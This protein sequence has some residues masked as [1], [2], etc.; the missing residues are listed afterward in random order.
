MAR[1]LDRHPTRPARR[2]RLRLHDPPTTPTPSTS[3]LSNSIKPGS[4]HRASSGSTAPKTRATPGSPSATACLSATSC[5]AP[6]DKPSATTPR[7]N[8]PPS[9][10]ISAP[11]AATSTPPPTA[12]SWQQILDHLAPIPPSV[13]PNSPRRSPVLFSAGARS[14]ARPRSRGGAPGPGVR[15]EG[16]VGGKERTQPSN[17]RKHGRP[18]FNADLPFQGIAGGMGEPP[19]PLPSPPWTRPSPSAAPPT[20]A[21]SP[22]PPSA[23]DLSSTP[24]WATSNFASS[25]AKSA[26]GPRSLPFT[27]ASYAVAARACPIATAPTSPRPSRQTTSS[28]SRMPWARTNSI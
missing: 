25:S 22:T 18:E 6:I 28:P 20:A 24:T 17:P 19:N 27:V 14:S 13:A 4:R 1:D 21:S 10:S 15:S 12:E 23:M 5:R 2:V 7:P 9:A 3:S 8:P 26:S 16:R 11:A